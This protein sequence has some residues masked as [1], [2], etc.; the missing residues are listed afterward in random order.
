MDKIYIYNNKKKLVGYF[1][2]SSVFVFGALYIIYNEQNIFYRVVGGYLGLVFFSFAMIVIF[3][4]IFHKGP[5]FIIDRQGIST[6]RHG[7]LT[8]D[9]INFIELVT[10][11]NDQFIYI[12]PKDPMSYFGKPK[13]SIMLQPSMLYSRSMR[14]VYEFMDDKMIK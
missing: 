8:W 10:I 11:N 7:L 1:L 6:K 14:E 5:L 4:Q 12:T 9:K 2:I 3:I 13:G